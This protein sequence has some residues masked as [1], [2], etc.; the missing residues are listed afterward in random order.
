MNLKD[1][2]YITKTVL[3]NADITTSSDFCCAAYQINSKTCPKFATRIEPILKYEIDNCAEDWVEN[4]IFAESKMAGSTAEEY[5]Q[6]MEAYRAALDFLLLN[7]DVASVFTMDHNDFIGWQ[8]YR[9]LDMKYK[10]CK[11]FYERLSYVE[12]KQSS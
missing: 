4:V 6:Y 12:S 8:I 10:H 9:E 7:D 2:E 1:I 11:K 3:K 5:R